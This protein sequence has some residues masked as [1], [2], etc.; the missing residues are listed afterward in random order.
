MCQ[1][2]IR[3]NDH[4]AIFL[5]FLR[6]IYSD[7]IGYVK[8]PRVRAAPVLPAPPVM[9]PIE[10][11]PAE[12][13]EGSAPSPAVSVP[14]LRSDSTYVNAVPLAFVPPSF[15]SGPAGTDGVAPR[16]PPGYSPSGAQIMRV[17]KMT[18]S[19][20]V[21]G[22]DLVETRKRRRDDDALMGSSKKQATN[23]LASSS[24]ASDQVIT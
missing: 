11:G 13:L 23:D 5:F 22:T 1:G 7:K 14:P 10:N 18:S 4:H 8:T 20:M 2:L 9:L 19:S 21:P 12:P 3:P 16:V 24:S 15:R 6:D 17:N